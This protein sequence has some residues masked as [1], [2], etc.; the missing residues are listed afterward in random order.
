MNTGTSIEVRGGV[1]APLVVTHPK[2]PVPRAPGRASRA[3]RRR[4]RCTGA[5]AHTTMIRARKFQW[6][7]LDHHTQ[8]LNLFLLADRRR[9]EQVG[10][11]E[12]HPRP[13]D[14]RGWRR[15]PRL[16]R[17][18]RGGRS[19]SLSRGTAR[20][21]GDSSTRKGG[22]QGEGPGHRAANP[23]GVD[24][25]GSTAH[26]AHQATEG[27]KDVGQGP[28]HLKDPGRKPA[29]SPPERSTEVRSHQGKHIRRCR[30][31]HAGRGES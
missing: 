1:L 14:R 3:G 28:Q 31:L 7:T 29:R 19:R 2:P 13:L 23:L 9:G 25:R 15:R 16:H 8:L 6:K 17:R 5:N 21:R 10:E 24:L 30:G 18:R 11:R 22:Q 20:A 12:L 4:S 26:G 27:P